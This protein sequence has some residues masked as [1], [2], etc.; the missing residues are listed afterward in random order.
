MVNANALM[1][2]YFFIKI[3]HFYRYIALALQTK[4]RCQRTSAAAYLEV[5]Q[6][7]QVRRQKQK[8]CGVNDAKSGL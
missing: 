3:S 2:G 7:E 6:K 4:I 1:R 5:A 8:E